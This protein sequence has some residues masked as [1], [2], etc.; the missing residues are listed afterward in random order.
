MSNMRE[1]L[2]RNGDEHRTTVWN[3]LDLKNSITEDQEALPRA[4]RFF[5]EAAKL[6]LDMRILALRAS[7]Y[8]SFPLR[9]E[10][11]NP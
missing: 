6:K 8:A 4:G 7:Q 11:E 2:V 9:G 5:I 10:H 1:Q 3:I